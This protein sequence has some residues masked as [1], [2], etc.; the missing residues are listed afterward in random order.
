MTTGSFLICSWAG[1]GNTQPAIYLG[2]RLRLRGHRV[3]F[4]GW[5]SMAGVVE[6]AGLE[7]AA[8]PSLAPWPEGEPIEAH[9][10]L[11]S[12]ALFGAGTTDDICSAAL[13][14]MPDV[15]V[16]DCMLHAGFVAAER[17]PAATVAL[18]H[19]LYQP[20]V[21]DWGDAAM[22]LGVAAELAR[23][24]QVLAVVPA[25]LDD[26]GPLPP[27]TSYRSRHGPDAR[28]APRGPRRAHR[29]W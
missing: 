18:V 12:E 28:A 26:P 13:A 20:F 16:L 6:A 24:D 29:A 21:H 17:L 23:A 14:D 2:Q 15:L 25:G 3:R 4:L 27:G 10:D 8:Y 1:G 22:E 9:W 7:F 5:P 11:M 19:V